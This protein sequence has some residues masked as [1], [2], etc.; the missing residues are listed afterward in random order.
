M[1][2]AAL[3]GTG[4][5]LRVGSSWGGFTGLLCI[6]QITACNIWINWV[7]PPN[8]TTRNF[9]NSLSVKH[10]QEWPLRNLSPAKIKQIVLMFRVWSMGAEEKHTCLGWK[11]T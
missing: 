1:Q 9:N 11:A 3:Y 10:P 2:E 4:S 8:T 6:L 5:R 7:A